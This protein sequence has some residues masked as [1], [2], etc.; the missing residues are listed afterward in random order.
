MKKHTRIKRKRNTAPPSLRLGALITVLTLIVAASAVLMLPALNVT[1]VYCE[2]NSNI[3]AEELISSSQIE[4]GKNIFL[5]NVGRAKR[6]A[7]KLAIVEKAEV[8]RIFPNKICISVTERTPAAYLT[9]GA[10][11]IAVASDGIVLKQINGDIARSIIEDNTPVPEEEQTD[12]DNKENKENTEDAEDIEDTEDTEDT[13]DAEDTE[14]TEDTENA[15]DTETTE[16]TEAAKETITKEEKPFNI[17]LVAGVEANEAREGDKLKKDKEGKLDEVIE[18]CKALAKAQLLERTTYID[19]TNIAD[20]RLVVENRL[21]IYIGEADN[22][23]YRIS[24]LAEVIEKNISSYEKVVMDYRGDDI[25]VRAHEDGKD[26]IVHNE[27]NE[28]DIDTDTDTD[29][30]EETNTDSNTEG[31]DTDSEN[32]DAGDTDTEDINTL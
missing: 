19:V 28:A 11:C 30:D 31:E 2:G 1:E 27:D 10:D 21:D 17:P 22:I 5:V 6:Q 7:E 18:I 15:E 29:T 26:R 3:T 4:T 24:F 20:I 23:D 32:A 9:R 16:D 13:E 12:K 14:N 25:Y 8:R